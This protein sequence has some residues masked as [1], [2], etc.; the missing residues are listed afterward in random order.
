MVRQIGDAGLVTMRA[1]VVYPAFDQDAVHASV[2]DAALRPAFGSP[3]DE[4]VDERGMP[5]RTGLHAQ[6]AAEDLEFDGVTDYAPF[7]ATAAGDIVRIGNASE[8]TLFDCRIEDE[9]QQ[10]IVDSLS[11]GQTVDLPRPANPDGVWFTCRAA[12]PPVLFV[13]P[14]FDV[15]TT[16][17]TIVSVP[18]MV[19]G[20][21]GAQ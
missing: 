5:L 2:A 13:D 8:T 18:I 1:R 11:P 4:W 15:R 10:P 14:R 16:G 21:R 6:G 19:S 12:T 7:R 20:D 17:T 3:R 9:Q